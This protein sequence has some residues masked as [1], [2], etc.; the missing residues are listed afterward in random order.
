MVVQVL[1]PLAL[2]LLV[3]LDVLDVDNQLVVEV[4]LPLRIINNNNTARISLAFL[5]FIIAQWRL[6]FFY[7]RSLA[8]F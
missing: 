6:S 3:L 7:D 1:K 8:S 2:L 5:Y 4:T